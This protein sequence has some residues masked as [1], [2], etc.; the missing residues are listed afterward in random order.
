MR[1]IRRRGR[2]VDP[3]RL[4]KAFFLL[5]LVEQSENELVPLDLRKRTAAIVTWHAA[6]LARSEDGER[7]REM[8]HRPRRK[9]ASNLVEP[10]SFGF[11][12]GELVTNRGRS[13]TTHRAV[14]LPRFPVRPRTIIEGDR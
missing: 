8:A 1:R 11:R 6:F 12:A 4:R 3:K 14:L 5:E 13:L 10:W 7:A 2:Q 9:T